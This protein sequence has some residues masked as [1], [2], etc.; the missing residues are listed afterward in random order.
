MS[1]FYFLYMLNVFFLILSTSFGMWGFIDLNSLLYLNEDVMLPLVSMTLLKD[2]F[3]ELTLDLSN[4]SFFL[5]DFSINEMG[6]DFLSSILLAIVECL[7]I[8]LS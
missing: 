6:T 8:D 4:L 2:L 3:L 5:E 7:A 1:L